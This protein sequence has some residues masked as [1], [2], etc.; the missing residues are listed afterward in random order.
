M[1]CEM[2]REAQKISQIFQNHCYVMYECPHQIRNNLTL[3]GNYIAVNI[4]I[5]FDIKHLHGPEHTAKSFAGL[6][7][8]QYSD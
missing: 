3:N 1:P 4:V 6:T 8:F 7:I 2:Y 5:Y